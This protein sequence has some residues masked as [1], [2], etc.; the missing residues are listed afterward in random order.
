MVGLLGC[1]LTLADQEVLTPEFDLERPDKGLGFALQR[2]G[3]D[4]IYG[5]LFSLVPCSVIWVLMLNAEIEIRIQWTTNKY[6]G[7]GCL[8]QRKGMDSIYVSL[9][10]LERDVPNK[11]TVGH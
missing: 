8:L 5:S 6:G 7:S 10:S 9:F 4:S 1:G 3:M 2:K 11:N